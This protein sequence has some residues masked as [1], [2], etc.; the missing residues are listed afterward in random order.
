MTIDKLLTNSTAC[1]T[2]EVSS[3]VFDDS[4]GGRFWIGQVAVQDV[5]KCP[6]YYNGA[7]KLRANVY[8]DDMHFLTPEHRDE[9]GHETD[10]DDRS[11]IHFAI[12]E[13]MPYGESARIVGTSRLIRKEDMDEKLPV[14]RIFPEAFVN[15]PAE[16]NSVEVSRFISRHEKKSTQHMISLSL[17]RAMTLYAVDNEIPSAYFLIE[18][19]LHRLLARIGLP[20]EILCDPKKVAEYGNTSNMVIRIKPKEIVDSC[21]EKGN[22]DLPIS[23]FFKNENGN[24]G[25]GLY[26]EGLVR[27]R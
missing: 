10:S 20:M 27:S 7:L 6:E 18:E 8:I 25:L 14:E 24:L 16:V 23:R 15:D 26:P 11:S 17:I 3:E 21:A 9:N 13:K 19:P 1:L 2:P 12:A 5:V 22:E 4:Y